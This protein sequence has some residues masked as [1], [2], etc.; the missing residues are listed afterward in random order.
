MSKDL[1]KL[2]LEMKQDN[3]LWG[4]KKITNELKKINIGI[5]YTT[6]YKIIH[7][8]FRK[9]GKIQ[10]NGSW[11]KFLK[12]HWDSLFSMDFMVI[13]TLLGKRFYIFIIFELKSRKI[14][15]FDLT[16]N[17]CRKFVKQRMELFS[18]DFEGKAITLI[19]DNASQF[20]SIDYSWFGIKGVNICSYAPNMNAFVER[21]NGSIRREA[22]DHF[23]L[24]SE[25]QIQKIISQVVFHC[26]NQRIH[27]GIDKILDAEIGKCSGN[28]RKLR[29]SPS[30]GAFARDRSRSGPKR[31]I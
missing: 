24:F 8:F 30:Q 23:L 29:T 13:D 3:P 22:L 14:I 18:E 25:K 28:I 9:Q 5:H 1:K 27:Q 17:S 2:I 15:R 7:T 16:E 21:L 11:S 6:L 26:N 20:T 31:C 4:C 19:Y 12:F 10:P